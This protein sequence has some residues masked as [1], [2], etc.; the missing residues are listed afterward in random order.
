MAC[1]PMAALPNNQAQREKMRKEL[2][3]FKLEYL[4]QELKLSPENQAEFSKLYSQMEAERNA[5]FNQVYNQVN[6]VR[7][8]KNPTDAEFAQA[9]DVMS[10]F[11]QREG[12][13]EYKYFEKFKKF[14]TPQQLFTLKRCEG[15]FNKKVMEMQ[16]K[17]KNHGKKQKGK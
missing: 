15:K 16:G 1:M 5:L 17:N 11:K 3:A 2:Q 12:A 9:A 4:T 10:T 8:K 13:I 7:N 14:L 6:A